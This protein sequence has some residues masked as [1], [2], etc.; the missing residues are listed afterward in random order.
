LG[1]CALYL[2]FGS[3]AGLAHVHESADHHQ[4]SRG[5]HLD[6]GHLDDPDGHDRHHGHHHYHATESAREPATRTAGGRVEH[7]DNDALYLN[8]AANRSV[9]PKIFQ[10]PAV[11]SAREVVDPPPQVFDR[12]DSTTGQPRDPPRKTLPR[13]RAPPA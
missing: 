7:H 4:E 5:L 1:C 10:M 6:H 3:V 13:L 8:A 2:L 11:V 9:L 12:G